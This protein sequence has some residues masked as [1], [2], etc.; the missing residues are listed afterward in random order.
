MKRP[1]AAGTADGTG[2]PSTRTRRIGQVPAPRAGG[3]PRRWTARSLPRSAA[4]CTTS[5]T[6][7]TGT[8]V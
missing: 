7:R 4:S 2:R 8:S 1:R 3:T 6:A 5:V